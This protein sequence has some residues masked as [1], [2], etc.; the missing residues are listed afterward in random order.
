M[1]NLK[2]KRIQYE[3]T[4]PISEIVPWL[5]IHGGNLVFN[6]DGSILAVFSLEGV[7]IEGMTQ[8]D[9]DSFA[10]AAE[11]AFREMSEQ[12]TIWSTVQRYKKNTYLDGAQFQDPYSQY[13]DDCWRSQ[14]EGGEL[15]A[16]RHYISVLYSP[17]T[18]TSGFFDKVSH[19]TKE[20]LH[21]IQALAWAAKTSLLKR[22]AFAFDAAKMENEVAAFRRL[23]DIFQTGMAP[24]G[25][26]Q[27]E[28]DSLRAVLFKHCSPASTHGDV[29]AS[30]IATYLDTYLPCDSMTVHDELLEFG[31]G[32]KKWVAALSVKDWPTSTQPGMLDQLLA[33][34]AEVTI[35]QVFRFVHDDEAEAFITKME[36]HNL[37]AAKSALTYIKEGITKEESNNVNTGRIQLA[38]DAQD[39]MRELTAERKRFGYYNLTILCMGNT[40]KQ[41]DEN[42]SLAA[43]AMRGCQFVSVRETLHL[44]SAWAG[45]L[46]GQWGELVRWHFVNIANLADL[47]HYRTIQTGPEINAYLTEEMRVEHPSLS[48]LTTE[49][50]T[51]YYFNFHV[52]DLAH[53]FVIGPSRNGKSI[54]INFLVSQ[55]RKYLKANAFIF[56]K[57]YSCYIPTLMQGGSYIDLLGEKEPAIKL[58]PLRFILEEKHWPWIKSFIELLLSYRNVALTADDDKTIQNAIEK[59]ALHGDPALRRLSAL[60]SHLD[61]RLSAE[62]DIWCE[63]GQFGNI[64]DNVEDEFNLSSFVAIEMGGL[65]SNEKLAVAFLD[66][67]FYSILQKL[68]G[69]PTLIEIEE[70]WFALS[71]PNMEKKIRDWLKTFA[72]KNAFIIMAT[73][74][75]DDLERSDIFSSIIDNMPTRIYLPNPNAM[76]NSHLYK[77]S[78][79]LNDE[80]I[81]RIRTATRKRNYYIVQGERSR[82]IDVSFPKEILAILRS[83]S[84]AINTFRKHR[85]SGHPDWRNNYLEEMTQ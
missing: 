25:I 30:K 51:P 39:A 2:Q 50:N 55:W 38:E 4:R 6:K 15:Y 12:I 8:I 19:F 34:P 63:G 48:M 9:I 84:D 3:K 60:K 17:K 79:G 45:T 14:I 28:E 82:M 57:D 36:K 11:S 37:A 72:K 59:V 67:A 58:N 13:V 49:L 76:A 66:Y 56:D 20:G 53:T 10:H 27:L 16:N 65:L 77:N 23:L 74:S 24:F 75:L 61:T 44:Q 73:Q 26:Q 69:T 32:Q 83:N 1:L 54:F 47:A 81:H 40:R 35:S 71:F 33:L 7:D 41:A 42:A 64:F 5:V 18:G 62:L 21:P 22:G 80:Q 68:D 52:G 78:F 70:C 31:N 46:P 85:S 43:K 29:R